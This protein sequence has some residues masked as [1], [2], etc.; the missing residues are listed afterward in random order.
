MP[1]VYSRKLGA[2]RF[3][4]YDEETLE[5]C[6][7]EV[8][9]GKISANRAAKKYKIPKGTLINKMHGRHIKKH[10]G[11]TVFSAAEEND[12]VEGLITC[13]KWG[14]PLNTLDLRLSAKSYLDRIGKNSRFKNNLPGRF[15]MFIST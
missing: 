9:D 13:A 7:S 12:F 11:Q 5:K 8:L 4:D 2:K 3:K 6:L 1:R 15:C 10:G 14:F